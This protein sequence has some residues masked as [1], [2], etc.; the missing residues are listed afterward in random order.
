MK[1]LKVIHVHEGEVGG[2]AISPGGDALASAGK[3]RNFVV[4]PLDLD[5]LVQSAKQRLA[6][7]G[8]P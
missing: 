6:A 8:S 7:L 3:D 5:Q 4:S 2:L 1:R